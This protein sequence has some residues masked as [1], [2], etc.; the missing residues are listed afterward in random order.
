MLTLWSDVVNATC[1]QP[2]LSSTLAFE[3][4]SLTPQTLATGF[5]PLDVALSTLSLISL[6]LLFYTNISDTN[7]SGVGHSSLSRGLAFDHTTIG[8]GFQNWLVVW[9]ITGAFG[10]QLRQYAQ[11]LTPVWGVLDSLDPLFSGL[12]L[13]FCLLLIC[14]VASFSN[15]YTVLHRSYADLVT[16]CQYRSISLAET[17]GLVSLFLGFIVFDA[18]VTL[19]EDDVFEGAG[20]IFSAII[21]SAV[22]FLFVGVDVQFVYLVCSISGAEPALRVI[23]NDFVNNVLCLLRVFLCWLRYVFYDLQ[24]EFL[25]LSF[26][27]TELGGA[28]AQLVTLT[29]AIFSGNS[30]GV[31]TTTTLVALYTLAFFLLES[32]FVVFQLLLGGVK[33]GL[34]LFLFW[35]I[36]D[37]FLLRLLARTEA[38]W[39][40]LKAPR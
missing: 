16:W 6:D 29:S 21:L 4:M 24:A 30:V 38:V 36:L 40:K 27:F 37:L 15:V 28:D 18:F 11:T 7:V 26:H 5:T 39:S 32:A 19:S 35:L 22:V 14:W 34:A 25:D 33:L 9:A 23:Y 3:A 12:E 1:F 20:W 10:V 31:S 2:N 8:L 17:F 13:L